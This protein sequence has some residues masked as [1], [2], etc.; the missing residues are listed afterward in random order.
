MSAARGFWC[1][2]AWVD[3][4][5]RDAVRLVVDGERLAAVSPDTRPEPADTRLAGLTLPGFGN[6]HSHMFHRALRGR[7]HHGGGDFWTWREVMYAVAAHLDPDSYLALARAAYA[8][9]VLAGYTAVGEFHYVH[10]GPDGTPYADPNVMG[11]ALQQAA[12]DAGIRLTLLD[13][14][15]LRGGLGPHGHTPLTAAQRRFGDADVDAW[16]QRAADRTTLPGVLLGT[17]IHSVRAVPAADLRTVAEQ[18]HR[19][20]STCPVHVHL[21]EQPA[22]N[23]A[24]AAV[25][26]RSPTELL[27]D[28]GLLEQGMAAVHATH[29]S[30]RDVALLGHYGSVVAC[31]T[32]ERDLA[33]GIGPMGALAEAGC[34]LAVGSDQHAVVDP[35]EELRALEMHERLTSG[36]RGRFSPAELL[37]IGTTGAYRVLGRGPSSLAVG[38]GADFVTL[39]TDT[40]R[41]AGARLDQLWYAAGAPDVRAVVVAG[42]QIVSGGSHRLG[43]VG[44]LLADA[45]AALTTGDRR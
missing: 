38:A 36:R 35:F 22:E 7:T 2:H 41:T 19:A 8:E 40:P 43:D 15:Y 20:G 37:H 34:E 25:Y 4:A 9:L 21:S 14:C 42:E 1:E 28:E 12:A 11:A 30:H 23:D 10:H 45:I 29:L 33:D 5:V 13:V 44:A 17:A 39:A 24:C 16:A 31:P 26:G 27:Y 32:T 3:G 18:A 6:A